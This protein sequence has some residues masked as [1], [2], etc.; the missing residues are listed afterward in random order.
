MGEWGQRRRGRRLPRES[1][2]HDGDRDDVGMMER[3][4]RISRSASLFAVLVGL[5]LPAVRLDAQAGNGG[6]R[7]APPDSTALYA[8]RFN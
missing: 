6:D 8:L 7:E 2:K 3:G 1:R 4:K 5:S